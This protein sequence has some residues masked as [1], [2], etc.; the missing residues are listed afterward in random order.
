MSTKILTQK[1]F[2]EKQLAEQKGDIWKY[3]QHKEGNK[4]IVVRIYSAEFAIDYYNGMDIEDSEC[5]NYSGEEANAWPVI[6]K[7]ANKFFKQYQF[8]GVSDDEE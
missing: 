2:K 5:G 4:S 1:S 3:Y 7:V 6:L 8:T